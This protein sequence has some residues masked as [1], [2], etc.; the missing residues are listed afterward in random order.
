MITQ[1]TTVPAGTAATLTPGE[2]GTGAPA[3]P[4]NAAVASGPLWPVTFL[5]GT[6]VVLDTGSALYAAL[7]G[8]GAL[9]AYVPG[10]DDV[11]HAALAN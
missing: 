7:N 11:G 2:P 10:T 8:A 5:E 3:G 6:P 9:R 1:T 4:G